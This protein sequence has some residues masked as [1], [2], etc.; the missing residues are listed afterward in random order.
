[1]YPGHIYPDIYIF[2]VSE[3]IPRHVS[4]DKEEGFGKKRQLAEDSR[5]V[6]NPVQCQFANWHTPTFERT[7]NGNSGG[8]LLTP[9]A[10]WL[11]RSL[12]TVALP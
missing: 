10:D 12:Q 7:N 6:A 1:M 4:Q 9:Q 8:R 5:K 2:V 3:D 11:G